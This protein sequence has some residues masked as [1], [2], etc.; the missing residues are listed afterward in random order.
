MHKVSWSNELTRGEAKDM[1]Q[2][3]VDSHETFTF[4]E[5]ELIT[6]MMMAE[7]ALPILF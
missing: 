3:S 5:F 2:D 6:R 7:Y 1:M 4:L